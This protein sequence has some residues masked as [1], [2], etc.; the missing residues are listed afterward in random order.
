M[1][2]FLKSNHLGKPCEECQPTVGLRTLTV[3][4]GMYS[5]QQS[6]NTPSRM[7]DV[8]NAV[9]NPHVINHFSI[10]LFCGNSHDITEY[11]V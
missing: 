9:T 5:D 3:T 4:L 11:S 1:R 2:T 8:P 6:Y 10:T 7:N